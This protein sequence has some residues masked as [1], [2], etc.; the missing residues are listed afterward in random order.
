MSMRQV[1][2]ALKPLVPARLRP[3]A[4]RL[5]AGLVRQHEPTYTEAELLSRMEEFNRNAER[6]W[7]G[8]A[9]DPAGRGHVLN[10]PLSTV[11]DTP[12]IL[13]RVGLVLEELD[14]GVGMT[15]LDFGAGSCWMSSFINRLRCRTVS[16]DI[17]RAAL[18]LGEQMFRSDPRHLLSLEPR[19]LPYDGERIPVADESV[20][21]VVCFDA[22]HHVPNQRRVLAEIHR[23][24][25]RGG[26]AV[27]AEPGE[28]HSH[29]DQSVFE[30][31][32]AGVLENDLDLPTLVTLAAEAGFDD[33][34]M[35][36]YPEPGAITVTAREYLRL[37]DG[38]A[39][40][41][42][43]GVLRDN[44]RHFYVMVMTKG[45]PVYDSRNPRRLEA[46]ISVVGAAAP[47][48]G[49]ASQQLGFRVRILNRGDTLW[50]HELDECGG[51]VCLGGHLLSAERDYLA[52]GYMRA[53]LPRSVAPGE[54]VEM[55]VPVHLPERRGRYILQ[56]DMVDEWIVWFEQEGS[57]STEVVLEVDS[58][59]DSR[60][61]HRFEARIEALNPAYGAKVRPGSPLDLR[62]RLHNTG[63]TVWLHEPAGALGTVSLGGHLVDFAGTLVAQDYLR[64]PLPRRVEPGET[65]DVDLTFAAPPRTGVFRLRLDPVAEGICWFEHH[66]SP[67]LE[68][69]LAT[70]DEMPDSAWPGVLS[71]TIELR[72]ER[73][74]IVAGPGSEVT[75]PVSVVNTGNT[76]WLAEAAGG[77]GRVGL[78]G[79]L[80]GE[81][82]E[83][84]DLDLFR[85]PVP[86]AVAP[87]GRL[88]L[89]ARFVAPDRPGRYRLDVDMVAEGVAWF[90]SR[91]SAVLHL[92]LDVADAEGTRV[93]GASG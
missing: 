23:V 19:F 3:Q 48:R 38:D 87:D 86:H 77:R 75:I 82:G 4:A 2:R 39:S 25:K 5:G 84:L 92:T 80:R 67:A 12:G 24:L 9:A 60:A 85:A 31:E 32:K 72:R 65:V 49:R 53:L 93:P 55:D 90:G 50:L 58:Y 35:K 52:R 70:N 8:I 63:D 69:E 15:V 44:L 59:P 36:P 40:I 16:V 83:V 45:R 74:P 34:L 18:E 73:G 33:V 17:S 21:R 41:F 1:L 6:H 76:L 66:G 51:Y 10:K 11:K 30:A 91:G 79:Q 64:A 71:A 68:V 46:A 43:M 62:L 22:F 20:D 78:G 13:Y 42:P 81:Q 56:L 37:I 57:K 61:P 47:L 27:F 54:Q 26:R 89:E 29:A 28:G 88:E 14:L 7:R